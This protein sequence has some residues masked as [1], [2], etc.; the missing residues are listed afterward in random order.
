M[1]END[2]INVNFSHPDLQMKNVD[3]PFQRPKNLHGHTV[4][5]RFAKIVQSGIFW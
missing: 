2:C 4:L 1:G 5:T 3:T